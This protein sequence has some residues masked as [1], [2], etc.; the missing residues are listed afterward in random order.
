MLARRSRDGLRQGLVRSNPIKA[1]RA[2]PGRDN[3]AARLDSRDTSHQTRLRSGKKSR[4]LAI[5]TAFFTAPMPGMAFK[6]VS[7]MPPRTPFRRI[8][9]TTVAAAR[10][11]P[12]IGIDRDSRRDSLAPPH[13]TTRSL[14]MS[15][16]PVPLTGLTLQTVFRACIVES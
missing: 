3:G 1:S 14:S 7:N 10:A 6:P 4:P 9:A 12:R 5:S 2:I 8:A 11:A 15:L 16:P 13:R